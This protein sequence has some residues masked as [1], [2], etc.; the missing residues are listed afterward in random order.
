MGRHALLLFNEAPPPPGTGFIGLD[1]KMLES[2]YGKLKR[3]LSCEH[4]QYEKFEIE[5][6]ITLGINAAK[7]KIESFFSDKEEYDVLLFY[8]IGHGVQDKNQPL[9]FL[10]KDSFKGRKKE[11]DYYSSDIDRNKTYSIADLEA[12]IKKTRANKIIIILD[13][14]YSG[15]THKQIRIEGIE[16]K[17]L[18][19]SSVTGASRAVIHQTKKMRSGAFT[20]GLLEGIE[21]GKAAQTLTG[22]I[23]LR[24]ALNY[25]HQWVKKKYPFQEPIKR[26][27]DE[28]GEELI[29]F[30]TDSFLEGRL[31]YLNPTCIYSKISRLLEIIKNNPGEDVIGLYR[32]INS[33]KP[34]EF[35]S[36]YSKE[37]PNK[38]IKFPTFSKHLK[39]CQQ[40]NI[41]QISDSVNL[42]KL[43]QKM[44]EK[45]CAHFN[46]NFR[47]GLL[48]YLRKYNI[49]LT[50]LIDKMNDL[51][52]GGFSTA[53]RPLWESFV[54]DEEKKIGFH[55]FSY[56]IKLLAVIGVIR[57]TRRRYY[58]PSKKR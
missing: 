21:K 22:R 1:E 41:I 5:P 15:V 34:K 27:S 53:M 26:G 24:E 32:L 4:E 54:Y 10:F 42:T 14:C 23:T 29:Y 50:N 3:I 55:D 40:F 8:Y 33:K 17:V 18:I 25:A 36:P 16:K 49:T 9:R 56:T 11:K 51:I 12:E 28:L 13:C 20:F 45:N 43:G 46:S 6:I 44:F 52:R 38:I 37:G 35:L 39:K 47:E 30:E 19:L 58:L 2:V 57:Y 7:K 48:F 31:D